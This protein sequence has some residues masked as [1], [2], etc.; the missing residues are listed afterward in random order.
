MD[1][2][3]RRR[4]YDRCLA[5]AAGMLNVGLQVQHFHDGVSSS[6]RDHIHDDIYEGAGVAVAHVFVQHVELAFGPLL[7]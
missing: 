4:Q 5:G 3:Q 1:Q 2:D 7:Q 6:H